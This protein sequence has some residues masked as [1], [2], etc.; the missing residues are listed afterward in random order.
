MHAVLESIKQKRNAA[1][2]NPTAGKARNPSEKPS[3]VL[4]HSENT[5]IAVRAFS[6][7]GN[8]SWCGHWLD[9]DETSCDREIMKEHLF[10]N[11]RLN[12]I[13]LQINQ[14]KYSHISFI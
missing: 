3:L 13:N 6:A 7:H 1:A 5:L 11:A 12:R 9:E 4:N 10:R 8:V 2:I 14:R